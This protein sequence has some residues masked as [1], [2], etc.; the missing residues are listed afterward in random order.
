VGVFF[1]VGSLAGA[2]VQ[3]AEQQRSRAQ[4]H[5]VQTIARSQALSLERQLDRCL[6][7]PFVLS[8]IVQR[9]GQ[10]SQFNTLAADIMRREGGIAYIE[11]AP[12]GITQQVYPRNEPVSTLDRS[13]FAATPPAA[14]AFSPS[15]LTVDPLDPQRSANTAMVG[16]LLVLVPAPK[17]KQTFWGVVSVGIHLDRLLHSA[18][19]HTIA[20][21]GYDYELSRL[22]G[23]AQTWGVIARS[24]STALTHP[25]TQA[26]AVPN[27]NWQLA[28]APKGGWPTSPQLLK[29]ALLAIFLSGVVT[30]GVARLL[31]LHQRLAAIAAVPRSDAPP[32]PSDQ[33]Q[34]LI[35]EPQTE[36][37]H[38]LEIELAVTLDK[39]AIAQQDVIR[40]QK[41][42]T[43]GQLA[44]G[45]AQDINLALTTIRTANTHIAN[46]LLLTLPDLPQLLQSMDSAQQA[47]FFALIQSAQSARTT[48]P[49]ADQRQFQHRA[50]AQQLS[51]RIN[52]PDLADRLVDLGMTSELDSVAPL[53]NSPNVLQLLSLAVAIIKLQTHSQM[54][55]VAAAQVAKLLFA[56]KS[57]SS[58]PSTPSTPVLTYIPTHLDIILTLYVHLLKN[59]ITIH[60]N[61]EPLPPI[62]CYPDELS[63]VWSN[64]IQNAIQA[65]QPEGQLTLAVTCQSATSPL[66]PTLVSPERGQCAEREMAE[67]GSTAVSRDFIVVS[68]TD[69]GPG[70]PPDVLPAIFNPFFTTKAVGEGSGLGLSISRKI[71]DKHRGKIAVDSQPGKTTIQV[72]LPMGAAEDGR[73]GDN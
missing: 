28:I 52:A 53:L 56:M 71:I 45:I 30:G 47:C 6:T 63:H 66:N 41:L 3:Q 15:A 51:A 72:W 27:G 46:T 49:Y 69:T 64:L 26:I 9:T 1:A 37:L 23:E 36:R 35:A 8:E 39:L 50:I 67:K 55:G 20:F 73:E 5:L 12:K 7:V 54:I 48:Q 42:A 58:R 70:I 29:E 11:L 57:Y 21:D 34:P 22:D 60:R 43:L 19:L 18:R 40:A 65:M 62:P 24:S 31:Y 59:G 33:V 61:Y 10:V 2:W 13:L 68:V 44:A 38:R 17:G 32:P 14:A 25:V 16:R 4:Y